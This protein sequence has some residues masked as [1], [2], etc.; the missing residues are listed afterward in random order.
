MH[1]LLF[2]FWTDIQSG[3]KPLNLQLIIKL[4]N[5]YVACIKRDISTLTHSIQSKKHNVLVNTFDN[6]KLKLRIKKKKNGH[7]FEWR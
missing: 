4:I 5:I 2:Q 3:N 1:K 7:P 6:I